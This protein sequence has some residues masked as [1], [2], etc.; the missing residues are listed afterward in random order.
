M[1][2]DAINVDAGPGSLSA[3]ADPAARNEIRKLWSCITARNGSAGDTDQ[4]YATQADL[5]ALKSN[6]LDSIE[7]PQQKPAGQS[8]GG[9]VF[10]GSGSIDIRPL[11][12]SW[13]N[14]NTWTLGETPGKNNWR[15]LALTSG[16]ITAF[17]SDTIMLE[18]GPTSYQAAIDVQKTSEGT[19]FNGL[20]GGNAAIYVQHRSGTSP[21]AP[22]LKSFGCYGMRVQAQSYVET[23]V[24]VGNAVAAGYF[25]TLNQTINGTGWGLKVEAWHKGANAT[26]SYGVEVNLLRYFLDGKTIGFHCRSASNAALY[27]NTNDYGLL[28]SGPVPINYA[29]SVGSGFLGVVQ[30][31]VGL[32]LTYAQAS[33]AAIMIAANQRFVVDGPENIVGFYYDPTGKIQFFSN[34]GPTSYIGND[35]SIGCSDILAT[36]HIGALNGN[37]NNMNVTN[38]SCANGNFLEVAVNDTLNAFTVNVS[39]MNTG[40]LTASNGRIDSMTFNNT[41]FIAFPSKGSSGD[42]PV[43]GFWNVPGVGRVALI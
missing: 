41:P 43:T 37:V 10:V 38:L 9:G 27:H 42:T 23:A 5:T 1:S 20:I 30:C 28:V 17:V 36:H 25:S 11:A 13:T 29:L 12:N 26:V 7:F 39:N 15:F 18:A 6:I 31:E 22:S 35:G 8:G 2:N 40:N 21:G 3:I 19:V 24:D 16:P 14:Y 32:D 4:V 33:R 34:I